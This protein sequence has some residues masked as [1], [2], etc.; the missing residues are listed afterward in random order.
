MHSVAGCRFC[1]IARNMLSLPF[2]T[3]IQVVLQRE[4][5]YQIENRRKY[6]R[7]RD[8]DRRPNKPDELFIFFHFVDTITS[9]RQQLPTIIIRN[10]LP[11]CL[12][13]CAVVTQNI[14]YFKTCIFANV[15]SET[16]NNTN[17]KGKAFVF[18]FFFSA[19]FTK[20][21]N[22]QLIYI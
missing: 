13:Q 21:C 3:F 16:C 2:A 11:L 7:D 4:C 22:A 19:S 1:L 10:H 8:S 15:S 17:A 5:E 6:T 9:L 20:N 14:L 18:S 12:N